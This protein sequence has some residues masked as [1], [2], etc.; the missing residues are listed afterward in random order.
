[1][2]FKKSPKRRY[3]FYVMNAY[4]IHRFNRCAAETSVNFLRDILFSLLYVLFLQLILKHMAVFSPMPAMDPYRWKSF[5]D[6]HY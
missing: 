5:Q 2:Y 6:R 4:L 3:H 1:M